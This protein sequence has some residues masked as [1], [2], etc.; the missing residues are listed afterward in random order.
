[1]KLNLEK[2]ATEIKTNFDREVNNPL[3]D[4]PTLDMVQSMRMFKDDFAAQV[5][6]TV[7]NNH[8]MSFKQAAVI[9]KGLEKNQEN[10]NTYIKYLPSDCVEQ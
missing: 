4:M 7:C 2:V 10:F 6:V 3:S 1:M 5:A 9:A 8:T